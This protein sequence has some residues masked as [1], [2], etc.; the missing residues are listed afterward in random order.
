M[1]APAALDRPGLRWAFR[2]LT[3]APVVV[4]VNCGRHTGR[5]YK[6]PVEI[7]A[8]Y[9]ERDEIVVS[10]LFGA[11][12]GWYRNLL[13]GGLIEV[14]RQGIARAMAC[15]EVDE[16]GRREAMDAYRAEHP[17]YS[18]VVVRV[19]VAVNRLDG[20]PNEAIVRQIPMLALTPQ[21]DLSA[22]GSVPRREDRATAEPDE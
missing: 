1:R 2:V 7:V 8:E 14:R 20:D 4:L 3:P 22:V 6:T 10:P 9:P 13:A 21:G 16:A 15:R 19:L 18:R 5:V 12:S 17:I 11:S